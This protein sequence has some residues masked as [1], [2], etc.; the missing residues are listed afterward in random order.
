MPQYF[1][2]QTKLFHMGKRCSPNFHSPRRVLAFALMEHM[3]SL[4]IK[5]LSKANLYLREPC[6]P[7]SSTCGL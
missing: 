3:I 4:R 7:E 5:N 2:I 1:S 6:K